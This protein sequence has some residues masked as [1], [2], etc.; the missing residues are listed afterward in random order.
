MQERQDNERD[1]NRDSFGFKRGYGRADVRR[2]CRSGNG[3][4]GR[5]D[6]AAYEIKGFTQALLSEKRRQFYKYI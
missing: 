2:A 3:A 5:S 4:S 6:V 1:S